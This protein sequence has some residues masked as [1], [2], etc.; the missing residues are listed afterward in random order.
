MTD[1]TN[2]APRVLNDEECQAVGGARF[3]RITT[4]AIGEEDGGGRMTTLAVGE[5]D[6]G[7]IRFP[8]LDA[9]LHL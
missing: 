4:L 1:E 9:K 8:V 2:S 5:E 7:A 3:D 6:G